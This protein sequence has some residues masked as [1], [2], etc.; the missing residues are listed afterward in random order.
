MNV[1]GPCTLDF[2]TMECTNAISSTQE[3][4]CGTRLLTHLPHWPCCFHS[5]GL[6]ITAPGTALEQFHLAARIE[7]LAVALDQLGLVIEGVALAGRAGHEELHHAFGF[8]GMMQALRV[9][10]AVRFS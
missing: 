6:C 3:A 2:A 4:R 8:G 5:H 7:L 10:P 1:A 9:R